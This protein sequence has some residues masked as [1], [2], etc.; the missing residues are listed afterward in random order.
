M[1]QLLEIEAIRFVVIRGHSLRVAID[2]DGGAAGGVNGADRLHTAPIELHRAPDAVTTAA[3]NH[4]RPAVAF[5]VLQTE[6]AGTRRGHHTL[7]GKDFQ[8]WVFFW[9]LIRNKVH[10]KK[11]KKLEK[12]DTGRKKIGKTQKKKL[13]K[14]SHFIKQ[15]S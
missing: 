6:I 7:F 10:Q 12:H 2:H 3:Q 4:Y 9:Y 13:E 11:K 14:K 15:Y 1:T 5:L 8:I